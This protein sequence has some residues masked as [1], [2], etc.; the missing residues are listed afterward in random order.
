MA[1]NHNTRLRSFWSLTR[2]RS[3]WSLSGSMTRDEFN[4]ALAE[5][6]VTQGELARL[7]GVTDGTVKKWEEGGPPPYVK[8]VLELL[9]ERNEL[10]RELDRSRAVLREV[11]RLTL[12]G[13]KG[14]SDE[15][16]GRSVGSL[17]HGPGPAAEADVG[18]G[19]GAAQQ[20]RGAITP[21]GAQAEGAAAAE[22]SAA[23]RGL[24]PPEG[25]KQAGRARL[26]L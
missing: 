16:L 14:I 8:P 9:R 3:P 21:E 7:L 18:D 2:L 19:V 13:E 5:A 1:D 25:L 20:G 15:D 17:E 11:H 4:A 10:A 12:P 26:V 24:V 6:E 22:P 23:E